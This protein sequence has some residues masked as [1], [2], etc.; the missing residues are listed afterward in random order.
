MELSVR[1]KGDRKKK[2][3]E[4]RERKG[5]ERETEI[6]TERLRDR[7]KG[8]KRVRE[9]RGECVCVCVNRQDREGITNKPEEMDSYSFDEHP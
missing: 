2:I 4:Q 7:E 5:G 9:E 6:E 1:V 3:G 8:R